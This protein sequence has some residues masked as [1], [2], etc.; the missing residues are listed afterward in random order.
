M[1]VGIHKLKIKE[2]EAKLA[3]NPGE[4]LENAELRLFVRGN[5]ESIKHIRLRIEQAVAE[6]FDEQ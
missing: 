1:S 4:F 6:I 2:K 5:R 3:Q